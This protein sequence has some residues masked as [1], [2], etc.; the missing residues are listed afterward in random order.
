MAY[1]GVLDDIRACVAR[2]TPSRVPVFGISQEFDVRMAGVTHDAYGC[3]ADAMVKVHTQAVERSDLDWVFHIPD[4]YPQFEPL[5]VQTKPM[6]GAPRAPLVYPELSERVI[7]QLRT[8]DFR[9]QGRMPAFLEAVQ[10]IKQRFGD[11]ICMTGN[12]SGPFGSVALMWGIDQ[13]LLLLV[14]EP[15]L[16]ERAMDFFVELQIGW[17]QAQLEAGADAIWLGDCVAT[18]AFISA[19]DYVQFALERTRLVADALRQAGAIIFYHGGE[20]SI[21]HLEHMVKVGADAMNI[22]EGADLAAVK[23]A[24]GHKSCLMGNIDG[25]A[26][27]EHG[28]VEQVRAETT[29]IMTIGKPGGGYIFN[30][31]EGISY[32]AKQQNMH[33]MVAGARE[34]G[35]Y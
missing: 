7:R 13:A 12:V 31:G 19:D 24:F 35:R 21:N 6:P 26:V 16:F 4:D 8:P 23:Q 2:V 20:K 22:G 28:S 25:I 10:R 30:S 32:H 11:T 1:V 27:L 18:S 17:G 15:A 3:D 29:R 14:D 34:H 9:T 33:A 5:G